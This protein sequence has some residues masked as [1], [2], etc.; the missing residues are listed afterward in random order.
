MGALA[1]SVEHL[2]KRYRLGNLGTQASSLREA[3]LSW[4]S[5]RSGQKKSSTPISFVQALDDV[6]FTVQQG[7]V[8]GIVGPNGAGKSTLLKIIS[9]ITLPDR[10]RVMGS[11][12]IA[13]LLEAGVGFHPELSGRENIFLSGN[14]LG[15]SNREIRSR[16]DEIVDFAEIGPFLDTPVKRYSSGMY[17]RLAFAIGAFLRPELWIVDEVLSVGDAA[18]QHK[19]L[20]RIRTIAREEGTT[21]LMVSHQLSLIGQIAHRA[22]WLDYGKIAAEGPPHQVI[23]AYLKAQS[24]QLWDWQPNPPF[25]WKQLSLT[26]ARLHPRL[27]KGQHVPDVHTPL[28]ICLQLRTHATVHHLQL[29]LQL[30]TLVG[31]CLFEQPSTPLS[32]P[33]GQWML[34]YEIP[35]DFLNEG[36]YYLSVFLTDLQTGDHSQV[37][38]CLVFDIAGNVHRAPFPEAE[39]RMGYVRPQ[40]AMTWKPSENAD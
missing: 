23:G 4:W 31:E 33:P 10:G 16:F 12:R 27:A 34:E 8:L 28:Q 24:G 19:C 35:G 17:I 32:L 37:D 13:S 36:S 26:R 20:H 30:F 15:M 18:F 2:S 21:I 1:L 5:T 11:G 40:F 3:L 7:E 29:S 6:S 25:C 9:R 39:R 22:I 38:A 14:I